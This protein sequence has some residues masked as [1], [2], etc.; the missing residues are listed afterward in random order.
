M[1]IILIA[2]CQRVTSKLSRLGS[3]PSPE[4]ECRGRLTTWT[5]ARNSAPERSGALSFVLGPLYT[6][7]YTAPKSSLQQFPVYG[8]LLPAAPNPGRGQHLRP[9]RPRPQQPRPVQHRGL[10]GGQQVCDTCYTR[11]VTRNTRHVTRNTLFTAGTTSTSGQA[12]GTI[13]RAMEEHQVSS[14]I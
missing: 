7:I 1:D 6:M 13:V 10:R 3:C 11:H 9:H 12:P 4:Y 5:T 8:V 2:C 14:H